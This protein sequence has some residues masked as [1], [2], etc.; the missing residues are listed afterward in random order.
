M[1]FLKPLR[2]INWKYIVGEILLLFVGINLAIWFNDWNSSTK[3]QQDKDFAIGTIKEEIN[4]NLKELSTSL[5]QNENMVGAFEAF[6]GYWYQKN[7]S[8]LLATPQ[9]LQNLQKT[10]PKFFT[11][12]DS[13]AMPDGHFHYRGQTYIFLELAELSE[14]AWTTAKNTQVTRRIDYPCL[15]ELESM[16]N[17][18]FTYSN[19]PL[20]PFLY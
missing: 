18:F 11:V 8:H 4:S 16:Y 20:L 9:E 17:L 13:T 15:Y 10:Y 19:I 3:A 6:K 5:K 14:I 2:K 12:K 1:P 7:S